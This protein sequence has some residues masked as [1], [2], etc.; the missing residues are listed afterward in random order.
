MVTEGNFVQPIQS[1]STPM[2]G[3]PFRFSRGLL[4]RDLRLRSNL[5]FRRIKM[6]FEFTVTK[7]GQVTEVE[8]LSSN[9]PS[10]LDNFMRK[11]FAKVRYRPGLLDGVPIDTPNVQL[12]QTF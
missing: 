3:N 12:T 4:V 8:L 2:L 9:A 10:K 7:S 6:T 11:V 5:N 1:R